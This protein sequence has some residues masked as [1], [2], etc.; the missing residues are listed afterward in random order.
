LEEPDLDYGT[1]FEK[2]EEYVHFLKDGN[3]WHPDIKRDLYPTQIIGFH[4]MMDHHRVG[5][6]LIADKVGTGKVLC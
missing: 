5:G 2:V 3:P 1:V 6:G 4:W